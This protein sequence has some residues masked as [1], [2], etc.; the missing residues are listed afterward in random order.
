MISTSPRLFTTGT[1]RESGVA[2][3]I[4]TSGVYALVDED[5]PN[6]VAATRFWAGI[7]ENDE[8]L[9]TTNYVVLETSALLQRRLGMRQVRRYQTAVVPDLRVEW[10]ER[11]VLSA[12][13]EQW[14]AADPR[15]LSLVDCVS[16]EVMRRLGLTSVFAFDADFRVQGFECFP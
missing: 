11:A 5:E 8:D 6:H 14:L 16:F 7:V 1:I 9:I 4:G 13:V 15:Q 10:I 2:I 3:F 12:P